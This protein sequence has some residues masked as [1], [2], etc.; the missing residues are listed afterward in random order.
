MYYRIEIINDFYDNIVRY[1]IIFVFT[2]DIG[3]T[4]DIVYYSHNLN[5]QNNNLRK[6]YLYFIPWI[7]KWSTIKCIRGIILLS[8][9]EYFITHVGFDRAFCATWSAC[10]PRVE[11]SAG[12]TDNLINAH[13]KKNVNYRYG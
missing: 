13:R 2:V 7:F 9:R 6:L 10:R 5:E 3:D 12:K 8:L 4:G 1:Y 11:L